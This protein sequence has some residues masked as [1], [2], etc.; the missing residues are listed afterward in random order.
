MVTLWNRADHYIFI[1]LVQIARN[2]SA[3]S[4]QFSY[5]FCA[6]FAL[7]PRNFLQGLIQYNVNAVYLF[8]LIEVFIFELS[9]VAD[10]IRLDLLQ[11]L[12]IFN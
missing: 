1:Q 4:A 5:K 10:V 7:F 3:F 8:L 11:V 9:V 12:N 2:F 6:N